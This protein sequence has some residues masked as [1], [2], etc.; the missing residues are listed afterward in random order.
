[1]T[2][3]LEAR[4]LPC[5]FCGGANVSTAWTRCTDEIQWHSVKCHDCKF[6]CMYRDTERQAIAAWN[7]R[8]TDA[9]Q[10]YREENER[11]TVTVI[12]V[13]TL[14]QNA[15]NPKDTTDG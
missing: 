7:T 2:Q 14:L 8:T 9:M 13:A 6:D 4:L 5:P 12:T 11:L 15:L 10:R 1:M 3:E